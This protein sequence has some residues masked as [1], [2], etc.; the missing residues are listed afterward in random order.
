ME[1][2][3]MSSEN[4]ENSEKNILRKLFHD[5]YSDV[6]SQERA[7][8]NRITIVALLI[9]IVATGFGIWYVVS[10]INKPFDEQIS[11]AL[12]NSNSVL[13]TNSQNTNDLSLLDPLRNEDVDEDGLSDYDELYVYKTSPYIADSDSDGISDRTE[14]ESGTDPNCPAGEN[15]GRSTAITNA[16]DA[17]AEDIFGE[18]TP[19]T[20]ETTD[21]ENLTPA[22]LRSILRN[23]GVPQE[24]LDNMSDDELMQAYQDVVG[25]ESSS[26][27]SEGTSDGDLSD[28]GAIT[29]E[30]LENLSPDEIRSFLESSG[31]PRE[32]LDAIDDATLEAIYYESLYDNIG[33][34]SP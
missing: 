29:F 8:R 19:T 13:N 17:A 27:G 6:D 18:L 21:P 30:T 28:T 4:E 10:E 34:S 23:S 11:Q 14:V 33:N 12:A 32:E 31:I 16:D 3:F 22:E 26:E 1:Q 24:L 9:V 25:T 20:E 5:P 15:C 2:T 7:A